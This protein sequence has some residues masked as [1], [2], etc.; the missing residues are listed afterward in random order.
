MLSLEAHSSWIGQYHDIVISKTKICI[1]YTLKYYD[2]GYREKVI[3]TPYITLSKRL[4]RDA[5]KS[6]TME[7]I[8]RSTYSHL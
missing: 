4:N 2:V 5:S 3:A 7:L 8:T 6:L 1:N